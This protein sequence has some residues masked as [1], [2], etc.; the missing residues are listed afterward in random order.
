MGGPP[1]ILRISGD[2]KVFLKKK[3]RNSQKKKFSRMENFKVKYLLNYAELR[4]AC[5]IHFFRAHYT[6]QKSLIPCQRLELNFKLKVEFKVLYA[7]M[8]P[9]SGQLLLV[10]SSLGPPWTHPKSQIFHF[11]CS[12]KKIKKITTTS[13]HMFRRCYKASNFVKIGRV[14]GGSWAGPCIRIS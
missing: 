3:F 8:G 6:Q 2:I 13:I 4:V 1:K 9:P 5:Q 11:L 14:M 7:P 10:H 12:K